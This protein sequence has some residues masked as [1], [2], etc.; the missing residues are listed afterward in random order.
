MAAP[1]APAFHYLNGSLGFPA[2][3]YEGGSEM[4]SF[5]FKSDTAKLQAVCD[6][7]FNTPTG[8]DLYY[9]PL[10]PIVLVT[11]AKNACSR[12]DVPPYDTWGS[13]AYNEVIFS[14]FVVR[15]KKR[16]SVWV[17]EHVS[18]LVPY[19]FVD[20]AIVMAGGR[21]VYGMPKA[22]G[23][24][25]LPDAPSAPDKH[26]SLESVST[27]RFSPDVP[28]SWL[29]VASIQQQPDSGQPGGHHAWAD[30]QEAFA[31]LRHLVFGGSHVEVP[32]IGLA[33]EVADMF[34]EQKL[35]FCSLRQVRSVAS[36]EAAA[37][38][39]AVEFSAKMLKFHGAGL[40]HGTYKIS[41]P[42]NALFPLA[43]DLGLANGQQAEAAFWLNWDFL[44]ETGRDIWT[45]QQRP[46]FWDLLR[47]LFNS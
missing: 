38:Q 3:F 7:W 24:I 16:G 47:R 46:T 30:M 37:Y 17:A 11:F 1:S 31:A 36:S 13:V 10:L 40:L 5:V 35:P 26:F 6:A 45:A 12:P 25:Q 19:I 15:V 23:R 39:A 33:V 32:G 43:D 4:M 2:P 41:L 27:A 18:A 22:L 21:E 20:D 14:I 8:G 44:F 28:F 34:L 29:P 42:P 9:Q